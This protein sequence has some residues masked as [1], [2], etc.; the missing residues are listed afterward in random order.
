MSYVRLDGLFYDHPIVVRLWARDPAAVGL[1]VKALSYCARHRLDGVMPKASVATLSP[2]PEDR[3]RQVEALLASEAW[4]E[5]A[6]GDSYILGRFHEPE[7]RRNLPERLRKAVIE[8]D[9]M[10]CQIC[11]EDI[12]DGD[13]HIDHIF[14]VSLGGADTLDNL[15][16]AHSACNVRKG[17]RV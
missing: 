8:R 16:A 1:Y 4:R 2:N 10:V 15:Q 14:P 13:L 7:K 5:S 6:D 12:P 9:G 17:A 3:K 11:G